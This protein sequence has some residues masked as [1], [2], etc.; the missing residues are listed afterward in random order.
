MLT[1]RVA[2]LACGT[3]AASAPARGGDDAAPPFVQLEYRAVTTNAEESAG[4]HV[5]RKTPLVP[6]TEETLRVALGARRVEIVEDARRTVL[7][8]G[9][10]RIL[11]VGPDGNYRESSLLAHVAFVEMEMTNRARLAKA[12]GAAGMKNPSLPPREISVLFGWRAKD[13]DTSVVTATD[14]A[15]IVFRDGDE[16]LARWTPSSERLD[17]AQRESLARFLQFRWHLHPAVRDAIVSDGRAPATLRFRWRNTGSLSTAEL[18]L[19][20]AKRT[21]AD[22][23]I[24]LHLRVFDESDP[25]SRVARRVLDPAKDDPA[26]PLAAEDFVQLARKARKDGRYEDAA[27]LLI[28]CGLATGNPVIDEV[29]E[30]RADDAARERVERLMGIMRRKDPA[31]SIDTIAA[32]DRTLFSRPHLLDVFRANALAAM[33]RIDDARDA[34]LGA[35][36]AAPWLTGAWK[37][38]G[39]LYYVQ[40]ETERTWLAWEA[41]RHAAP[42]HPM[43][44]QI[45]DYENRLRE[46]FRALL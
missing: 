2:I 45:R 8:H 40:F 29:R 44:K 7:D 41:G 21:G 9:H 31:K 37:D 46:T 14:G 28:E 17:E 39:D 43:W 30:L 33:N 36:A 20:G 4:E 15:A 27:L 26:T 32:L 16:E 11:R 6:R 10:E 3:L 12:L 34:M 35:L 22:G 23:L 25:L 24:P 18:T 13:D 42:D 5:Q 1:R 19:L 38:L